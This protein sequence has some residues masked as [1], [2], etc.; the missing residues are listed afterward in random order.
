MGPEPEPGGLLSLQI[1]PSCGSSPQTSG[2][3]YAGCLLAPLGPGPVPLGGLRLGPTPEFLVQDSVW[4]G[5][6]P[7]LCLGPGTR[8]WGPT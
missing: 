6:G 2:T 1:P 8:G 5:R 7:T 4:L 3:R